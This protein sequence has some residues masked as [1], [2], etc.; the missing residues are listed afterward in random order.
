MHTFTTIGGDAAHPAMQTPNTCFMSPSNQQCLSNE[1][2]MWCVPA[3][4]RL[5]CTEMTSWLYSCTLGFRDHLCCNLSGNEKNIT[6][7]PHQSWYDIVIYVISSLSNE[8]HLSPF[9]WIFTF[10]YRW[11]ISLLSL[12]VSA[13]VQMTNE[14][15]FYGQCF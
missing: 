13:G 8:N 14:K 4:P 7:L 2:S 11:N 15:W 10:Y 9:L 6:I 1:C 3:R 5:I 12:L